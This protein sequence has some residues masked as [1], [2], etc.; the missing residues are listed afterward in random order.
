MVARREDRV[1][2]SDLEL[3][4]DNIVEGYNAGSTLKTLA[5]LY[6]CSSGLIR[7]ILLENGVVLRSRGRQRHTLAQQIL[8]VR[9]VTI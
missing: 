8:E 9:E 7:T 1:N 2:R 4:E 3:F 5:T 6:N